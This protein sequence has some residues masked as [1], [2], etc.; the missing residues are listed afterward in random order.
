[1]QVNK[2]YKLS[3]E[4]AA[5]KQLEQLQVIDEINKYLNDTENILKGVLKAGSK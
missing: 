3:N 1:M 2:K 4:R 5:A